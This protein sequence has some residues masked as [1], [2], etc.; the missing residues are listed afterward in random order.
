MKLFSNFVLSVILISFSFSL[1]YCGGNPAEEAE[2]AFQSGNYKM[3]IQLFGKAREQDPNNQTYD[4][5]IA[6]SF[7]HRGLD[8]FKKT[9]NIKAFA[10]NFEKAS[11]YIPESP[12]A[13]FKISYSAMSRHF[14]NC[15]S[16]KNWNS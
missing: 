9:N 7:M 6:L 11:E 16:S 12:S 15:R 10:G 3:A 5:K 14:G 2:K 4:E 13:E 1:F 8:F